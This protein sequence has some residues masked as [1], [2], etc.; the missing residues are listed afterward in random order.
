MNDFQLNGI[1]HQVIN[2]RIFIH[3][4]IIVVNIAVIQNGYLKP[5]SNQNELD[6]AKGKIIASNSWADM[7][8]QF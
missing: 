6:P 1:A 8:D 7:V 2:Q 5:L 4:W 3:F